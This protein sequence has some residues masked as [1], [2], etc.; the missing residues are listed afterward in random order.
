MKKSYVILLFFSILLIF[1]SNCKGNF[2]VQPREL[3]IK[4]EDEF[5][6]GNTSK[7]IVVTNN[8]EKEINISWYLDNPTQDLIRENKTII[9]SLSW[10][11]IEPQWKIIPSNGS[12]IFYIYL[13]IPEEKDN[14]NQHWETWPV[15][16]QEE[17]QFFNWEHAIRLYID[18]PETHQNDNK[19]N[20]NLFSFFSENSLIIFLI[21]IICISVGISLLFITIKTKKNKKS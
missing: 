1:T 13:D 8:I 12:S 5:I 16:K 4:M 17:S 21:L 9:P 6:Q 18:T 10:I 2:N 7:K 15:F 3:S 19:K 11:I 14:Y 20:Q